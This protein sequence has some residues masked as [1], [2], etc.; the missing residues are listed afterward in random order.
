M[1]GVH[2]DK[3]RKM[4]VDANG[5]P[6]NQLNVLASNDVTGAVP[7]GVEQEIKNVVAN[8]V[9]KSRLPDASGTI[10]DIPAYN[11]KS[12]NFF[13]FRQAINKKLYAG[14]GP[15]K[16]LVIG[17]STSMGAYATG[18]TQ[19]AD[20]LG[21]WPVQFRNFLRNNIAPCTYT[22]GIP[23]PLGASYS[24]PR[25]VI[26]GAGVAYGDTGP[27][28]LGSKGFFRFGRDAPG[29]I[30][31]TPGNKCDTIKVYF[32]Q[33]PGQ[34]TL[35]VTIDGSSVANIVTG[36][37]PS[38][39]GVATYTV[40]A[41][42]NHVVVVGPPVA[43]S[44]GG[45]GDSFIMGIECYMANTPEIQICNGGINASKTGDWNVTGGSAPWNSVN[46][47]NLWQP[48]LTIIDLTINDCFFQVPTATAQTNLQVLI[49]AA[50]LTGDVI[51]TSLL[52]S[53][54]GQTGSE[55]QP[56][57][58]DMVKNLAASQNV[59]MVDLYGRYQGSWNYLNAKGWEHDGLGHLFDA[60]YTDLASTM[61]DVIRVI[62]HGHC[63]N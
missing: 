36:A 46:F 31:Y 57:W 3:K 55:T 25:W 14:S 45:T 5:Y 22:F 23:T 53:Q 63:L 32:A 21:P 52:P 29:S 15:V 56:A 51:L 37:S 24:D 60:G 50:K 1:S 41:G 30:T 42:T 20:G 7:N 39:W 35:P 8:Y 6:V 59:G 12:V 27:V 54:Y 10:S 47:I 49:T 17:D 18:G 13:K 58:R 40:T 62:L 11:I 4:L 34:Q 26:S 48:D 38:Q 33:L 43:G 19:Q 44:G 16:I 61:Y 28:G 9:P 2:F